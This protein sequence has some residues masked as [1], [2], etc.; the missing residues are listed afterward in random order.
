MNVHTTRIVRVG[1]SRGVRI[2][3]LMIDQAGLGEQVEISIREE[4]LVISAAHGRRAGWDAQF[5]AMA[6][7][8]DDRMTDGFPATRWD[9][10]EWTW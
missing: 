7:N 10:T 2:P 6:E 4:G 8:K 5:A 3:K 9:E 1:N